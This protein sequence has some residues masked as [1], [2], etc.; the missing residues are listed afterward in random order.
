MPLE[1]QIFLIYLTL[2]INNGLSF[3][4]ATVEHLPSMLLKKIILDLKYQTFC[5]IDQD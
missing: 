5:F 3:V 4:V 1:E 2:N